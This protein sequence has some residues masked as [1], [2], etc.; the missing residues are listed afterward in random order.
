MEI[1]V[2]GSRNAK[3]ALLEAAEDLGNLKEVRHTNN[4]LN[5]DH[6]QMHARTVFVFEEEE[7]IVFTDFTNGYKGVGPNCLY[8]VMVHFG[9]NESEAAQLVYENNTAFSLRIA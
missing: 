2:S 5:N 7:I 3:K 6:S 8:E 1:R 9:V 4:H